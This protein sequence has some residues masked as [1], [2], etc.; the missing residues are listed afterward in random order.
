MDTVM[1]PVQNGRGRRRRWSGEQKLTV[2]QEWQ[3]GV[4]LEEICRKYAVNAAQMYR[5]KRSLDQGLKE[6]GELVP[7]SLGG[8]LQ[9]RIEALERAL[10]R[11]ALEGDILKKAFELKGLKSPEGPYGGERARRAAPSPWSAESWASRGVGGTIDGNLGA[12][13]R[14]GARNSKRWFGNS[15]GPAPPPTAIGGSLHCSSDAGGVQSQNGVAG[16][17]S[18]RGAVDQSETHHPIW[19]AT[20]RARASVGTHPALG[21][22][23]D[24][25]PS[26]GW[27]EGPL[28]CHARLRGPHGVGVA[29]CQ[30]DDSQRSRRDAAGGRVAPVW[31]STDPR[32][33]HRVPQRQRAG[34]HVA[35]GPTVRAGHGTHPLPPA[36]TESG[37]KRLGGGI[38]RQLQARRCLSGV[39]RNGGRRR[40]SPSGVDRTRQSAG[41]AQR[42][43]HAVASRVRCGVVSQKQDSTCPKLGGAEQTP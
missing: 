1:K 35:S 12:D 11:K 10:G 43:G 22:R 41:A 34:I 15:W 38:L 32:T 7:K 13:D 39:S 37:V 19:A 27:P 31:R 3:T 24:Q 8:G 20:R 23:H 4:P 26:V 6:P 21:R 33:R 14:S 25:Y 17:A 36:P 42:G 16:V 9:K 28:G 2:L 5:W 29:I 40:A 30:A 18:A